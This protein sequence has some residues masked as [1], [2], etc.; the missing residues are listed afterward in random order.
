PLI[1]ERI[2]WA[3]ETITA[4]RDH[5]FGAARDMV[6]TGSGLNLS[7]EV[8]RLLNEMQ[9]GE[10]QLL[11]ADRSHA[12]IASTA[13]FLLLPLGMFLSLAV[14]SSGVFFLNAG[15]GKGAQSERALGQSEE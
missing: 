3:D 12:R 1:A 8:L 11:E 5:G 14:L 2:G 15:V 13:T 7:E 4:R 6:A 9:S 10:Y